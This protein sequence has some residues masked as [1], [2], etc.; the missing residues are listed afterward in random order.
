M[1]IDVD[2]LSHLALS[3]SPSLFRHHIKCCFYLNPHENVHIFRTLFIELRSFIYSFLLDSTQ[4]ISAQ[5]SHHGAF[6]AS[7]PSPGRGGAPRAGGWVTTS[8]SEAETGPWSPIRSRGRLST[9]H[10]S[11]GHQ[12]PRLRRPGPGTGTGGWSQTSGLR[13]PVP[14][15]RLATRH[16]SASLQ[17]C[18]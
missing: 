2:I 11:P 8:Q 4:T 5:I 10:R 13:V 14:P 18:T 7:G 15:V 1:Y 17:P 16:S 12:W 9:G 3:Y 6:A